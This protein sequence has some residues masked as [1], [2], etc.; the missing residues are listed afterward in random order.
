MKIEKKCSVCGN[1]VL[2]DNYGNGRCKNC[3]WLQ[4]Y[5]AIKYP[6]AINPPNFTSLNNAK[7]L[8]KNHIKFYPSLN[9]ILKLVARGFDISF[10]YKNKR[11]QLDKHDTFTCWEVNTNNY[12]EFKNIEDLLNNLKIDGD[13]LKDCW[14]KVHQLRYE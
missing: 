6:N 3:N 2:I 9:D 12:M 4:D 10:V 11:Y 13:F 14:G 1:I 5:E 8:W 7:E